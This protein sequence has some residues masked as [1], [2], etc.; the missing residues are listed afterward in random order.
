MALAFVI[1]PIHFQYLNSSSKLERDIAQFSLATLDLETS[2]VSVWHECV[3]VR[4][5][6]VQL[7]S[8]SA[9]TSCDGTRFA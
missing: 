7:F 6:K 4:T 5:C 8:Q 3:L 1:V 2:R 9:V